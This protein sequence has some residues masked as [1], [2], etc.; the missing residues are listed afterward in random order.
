MFTLNLVP[1]AEK[2]LLRAGGDDPLEL[3]DS[4]ASVTDRRCFDREVVLRV[5]HALSDRRVEVRLLA[6]HALGE[7]SDPFPEATPF[8]VKS[9]RDESPF[10]RKA[11]V[12]ALG[13]H[14]AGDSVALAALE[15]SFGD[16][17]SNTL[18]REILTVVR[19]LQKHARDGAT[20]ADGDADA[21][22]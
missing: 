1:D 13:L 7:M 15:R 10:V 21:A 3:F 17:T 16:Q 8:L 5:L 9:L 12:A 19:R 18:R 4:I 14:G 20:P 6:A 2:G 22:K 11:A